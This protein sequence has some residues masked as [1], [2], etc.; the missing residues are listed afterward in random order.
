MRLA[1]VTFAVL[2]NLL[3]IHDAFAFEWSSD[4]LGID[5]TVNNR[6]SGGVG[7]RMNDIDY[8]LVGKQNV[9]GQKDLCVADNC[10]SLTGDPGPNQRLL[11]ATGAFSGINA[12][13]G[14]LNYQRFDA[15]AAPLR[16]KPDLTAKI[17]DD[18]LVRLSAIGTYDFINADFK[19]R[20]NDTNYQPSRTKRPDYLADRYAKRI[21]LDLAYLEYSFSWLG[22]NASLAVGNQH[23]RWGES[24]LIALNSVSEINPPNANI[25]HTPGANT[26]EIFQ[27]TNAIVLSTDVVDSVSGEFI[28][29]LQWKPVS[30]DVSGSFFSTNDLAGGG[31]YAYASLGQ[32]GENPNKKPTFGFPLN[33]VSSSTVTSYLDERKGRSSGQYG[34]R[35][36]YNADWLNG[37]TELSLYYLNYTSRLPYAA[38][39]AAQDSCAR[40]GVAGCLQY[41]LDF[42]AHSMPFDSIRPHLVYPSDIHMMALSFNTN[43]GKFSL[44]GELSYRPNLPLQV[45]VTD[46]LYAAQIPSLPVSPIALGGIGVPSAD[47]F[48]PSY[49]AHYRGFGN[50][51]SYSN[52]NCNPNAA[53]I[54]GGQYFNSYERQRVGQFDFTAIRL[55][56]E[57]PFGADQVI[58]I[59]EVGGTWVMNM[60]STQVLQFETG[61]PNLS[62]AACGA[63][64]SGGTNFLT[65]QPCTT[66]EFNPTQTPMSRYANSFSWGL[67]SIMQLEYN[68]VIFGWTINPQFVA[69][70]DVKGTAPLPIQ[71]FVNKR[72][73]FDVGTEFVITQNLV[74]RVNYEIYTGGGTANA[75]HD[76]DNFTASFSYSF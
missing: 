76:R 17:G 71:N 24:S 54:A 31:R 13:D 14:D 3:A 30:P 68:D 34:A 66:A 63:D 74:T 57:N 35:I 4:D 26:S 44:A 16:L 42:R 56:S 11:R 50:C 47:S 12:D 52:G 70:W 19:E 20:H 39:T 28:Y 69:M 45:A 64:G 25:L 5:V 6:F 41:G 10:I 38:F 40:D 51:T 48:I 67:R 53:R 18:W 22:R 62:H 36:N 58:S 55:F 59:N 75:L 7:I 43:V 23:I 29:Q 61:D 1:S 49:L 8:R 37:G 73:Q 9:P 60:P 33:L 46:A 2:I 65:G 15:Y 72:K 21:D 32:F 27:A